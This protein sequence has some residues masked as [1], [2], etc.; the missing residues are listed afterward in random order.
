[1]LLRQKMFLIWNQFKPMAYNS[2]HAWCQRLLLIIRLNSRI[3]PLEGPN[4]FMSR[5]TLIIPGDP[6]QWYFSV[7]SK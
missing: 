4:S 7:T 6:S 3:N 2:S 1:M 5:H